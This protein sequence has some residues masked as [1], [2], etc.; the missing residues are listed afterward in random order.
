[1]SGGQIASH[2]NV[3]VRLTRTRRLAF[4]KLELY[5]SV[6]IR[7]GITD[8]ELGRRVEHE[9]CPRLAQPGAP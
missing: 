8:L 4:R 6:G 3:S 7:I 1:M 9:R 2:K 5:N